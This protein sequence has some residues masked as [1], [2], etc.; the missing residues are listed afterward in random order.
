MLLFS[1]LRPS[2]ARHAHLN[3]R[4]S[5]T[6]LGTVM[7]PRCAQRVLAHVLHAL[8]PHGRPG[9]PSCTASRLPCGW[10]T[11]H[12]L[13]IHGLVLQEAAERSHVCADD[14]NV[15]KKR[16]PTLSSAHLPAPPILPRTRAVP[17][18]RKRSPPHNRRTTAHAAATPPTS[19]QRTEPCAQHKHNRNER[20][21]AHTTPRR[22]P[23]HSPTE[24]RSASQQAVAPCTQSAP[25]RV[26]PAGRRP[27][28]G[29]L[30]DYHLLG[31]VAA[32]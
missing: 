11:P 15:R 1:P 14:A 9:W 30:P 31:E 32:R 13:S 10:S 20:D 19:Q 21:G 29:A 3:T 4:P 22:G 5:S 26:R 6:G 2:Q 27:I 7:R 16:P 28:L 25:L 17:W 8:Q 24:Q 23:S 12:I 18:K